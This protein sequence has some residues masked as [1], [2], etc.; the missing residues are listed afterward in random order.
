[1]RDTT[2]LRK[3]KIT[4]M[5]QLGSFLLFLISSC[6]SSPEKPVVHI[7]VIDNAKEEASDLIQKISSMGYSVR[8][9]GEIM[10]EGIDDPSMI[11]PRLIRNAEIV[12]ELQQ[13]SVMSGIGKLDVAVQSAGSHFYNTD[14]IGIYLPGER[15]DITPR[16]DLSDLL[17]S[18][19][20]FHG[21]CDSEDVELNLF[22]A[23]IGLVRVFSWNDLLREESIENLP[24]T[25]RLDSDSLIIELDDQPK[26]KYEVVEF[27]EPTGAGVYSGVTLKR[28]SSAPRFVSCDFEYRNFKPR[29]M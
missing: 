15:E 13:A 11:I 21:N 1:M 5:A 23:N 28:V 16:K 6:V 19:K 18:Y 4:V 20:T 9:S 27:E 25:W 26:A 29:R 3:V 2:R 24:G 12:D 7:F 17:I 10:P 22:E 14:H 8:V